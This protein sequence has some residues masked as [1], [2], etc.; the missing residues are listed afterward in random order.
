MP[1]EHVCQGMPVEI[2]N[3]LHYVRSLRFEDR[4]DYTGIRTIFKKLLIKEGFEYDHIYDWVIVN[5]Q[6]IG[7]NMFSVES[8]EDIRFREDRKKNESLD[9]NKEED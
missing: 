6:H 1:I 9:G 2:A 5:Q 8:F 4:P 3:Y 7:S